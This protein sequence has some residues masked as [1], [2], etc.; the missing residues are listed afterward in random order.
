MVK[1]APAAGPGAQFVLSDA[2]P[3]EIGELLPAQSLQTLDG[4]HFPLRASASQRPL[5]VL[6]FLAYVST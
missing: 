2:A 1:I 3:I 5:T 6:V 4:R